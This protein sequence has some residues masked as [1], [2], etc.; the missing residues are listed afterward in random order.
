MVR[1][2]DIGSLRDSTRPNNMPPYNWGDLAYWVSRPGLRQWD[3]RTTRI[4]PSVDWA[5]DSR[6]IFS[7]SVDKLVVCFLST[8]SVIYESN[9]SKIVALKRNHFT[10][11]HIPSLRFALNLGSTC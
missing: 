11:E 4:A 8:V 5:Y 1:V 9:K 2:L 3:L 7:V 6:E 10:E